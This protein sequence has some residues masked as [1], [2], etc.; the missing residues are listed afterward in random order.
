MALQSAYLFLG[1][2]GDLLL[3]SYG[4]PHHLLGFDLLVLRSLEEYLKTLDFVREGLTLTLHEFFIPLE[5][6]QDQIS[7]NRLALM[8]PEADTRRVEIE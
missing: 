7:C 2:L 8:S 1:S 3:G 5:G 4:I 6:N